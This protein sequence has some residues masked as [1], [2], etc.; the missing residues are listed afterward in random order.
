MPVK[1]R[2]IDVD[3]ETLGLGGLDGRD[4]A[5]EYTGL[6]NR[7]VVVVFQTVQMHREKQ[8]WRRF[9][10][11][12]FLF[13]QQ[14][15]GADRHEFLAC[16][17]TTDDLANFLVDQ[18]LAAGDRH[19]RRATFVGGIPAFLRRHAAIEDRVGI[20]DLAAADAGEVAAKQRLEHQHQRITLSAKHLLLDQI[21]ADT[22]FLEERYCHCHYKFLSGLSRE[23]DQP[24]VSSAGSRNSIF[25]SRPGSTDTI[26]G[27]IRLKA[28]ITSS[29]RTSGAEAPAVIPTA[30]ASFS[31]SG[32]SSLP[33]A[34]R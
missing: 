17:Q 14:G 2:G 21:T 16:H 4:R 3:G 20:V 27:P 13:Q 30:L 32:F 11:M 29:T 34:I 7:L 33:S 12:E 6:R 31:Q 23:V 9:E 24:A 26:T 5:I 25:S 18:R 1:D 19:H 28:S 22:D 15:V 10:Q 8:I